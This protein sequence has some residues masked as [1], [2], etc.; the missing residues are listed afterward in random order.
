LADGAAAPTHHTSPARAPATAC[1]THAPQPHS[2]ASP[3]KRSSSWPRLA[4][5]DHLV[6]RALPLME[7][8]CAPVR[9]PCAPC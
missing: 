1:M 2:W 8:A 9:D 6:L 7:R 3:W 4:R 5:W